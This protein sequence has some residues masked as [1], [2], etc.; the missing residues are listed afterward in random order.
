MLQ[1]LTVV[2]GSRATVFGRQASVSFETM[3]AAGGT[4]NRLLLGFNS[5]NSTLYLQLNASLLFNKP[6]VPIMSKIQQDRDIEIGRRVLG[7]GNMEVKVNIGGYEMSSTLEELQSGADSKLL[8]PLKVTKVIG[9]GMKEYLG[10]KSESFAYINSIRNG[11]SKAVGSVLRTKHLKKKFI[12]KALYNS[13]Y[14]GRTLK[15]SPRTMEYR[16]STVHSGIRVKNVKIM[17]GFSQEYKLML[18]RNTCEMYVLLKNGIEVAKFEQRWHPYYYMP[19]NYR[20]LIGLLGLQTGT[21]QLSARNFVDRFSPSRF[22]NDLTAEQVMDEL[23][24]MPSQYYYPFLSLVGFDE[25]SANQIVQMI[26]NIPFFEDVADANEYASAPE[27]V[28]SCASFVI[29]QLISEVS[30]G[31]RAHLEVDSDISTVLLSH[32][33]ALIADELNVACSLSSLKKDVRCFIRLPTITLL[34]KL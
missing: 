7:N 26:P 2:N 6:K 22:R 13:N 19:R 4:T 18:P 5:P 10:S 33:V 30:P 32:Y 31:A 23:K 11:A 17:Y 9:K 28:K 34:N 12:E 3:A 15:D 25:Q 1:I 27:V 8:D 14:I 20:Y 16:E 21:E 24:R 29:K